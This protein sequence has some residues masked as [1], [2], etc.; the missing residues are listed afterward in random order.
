LLAL[1]AGVEHLERDHTLK[2]GIDGLVDDAHGPLAERTT[3]HVAAY[4]SRGLAVVEGH[5][6]RETHER[7]ALVTCIEV[8]R[9]IRDLRLAQRPFD[10]GLEAC[11][12]RTIHAIAL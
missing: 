12:G 10:E 3:K 8:D 7:S 9:E 11:F 1:F 4:F 6:E 5:G 2:V